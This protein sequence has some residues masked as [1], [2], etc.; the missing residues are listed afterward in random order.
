MGA[1]DIHE[2]RQ[3]CSHHFGRLHF[4]RADIHNDASRPQVR[5]HASDGAR[6]LADRDGKDHDIA[7][8]CGRNVA[9]MDPVTERSA[10]LR[11]DWIVDGEREM[12]MQ[13]RGNELAEG[14]ETDQSDCGGRV[15]IRGLRVAPSKLR[16][17]MLACDQPPERSGCARECARRYVDGG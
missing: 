13:M 12:W 17:R 5:P 9:D 6:Q 16:C 10:D 15:D 1:D 14:T 3:L 7:A 8:R 11:L 2:R 4:D